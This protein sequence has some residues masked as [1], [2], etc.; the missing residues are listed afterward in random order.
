[1]VMFMVPFF[2]SFS[3][4][5]FNPKIEILRRRFDAFPEFRMR[6]IKVL[7]FNSDTS[8][9]INC[10]CAYKAT[11]PEIAA[12]FHEL[13]AKSIENGFFLPFP[14]ILSLGIVGA[15]PTSLPDGTFY[16]T[17]VNILRD[18]GIDVPDPL[19]VLVDPPP[20]QESAENLKI[21]SKREFQDNGVQDGPAVK[22][23]KMTTT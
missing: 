22:K 20:R 16:G 5:D 8:I 7:S 17:P 9:I 3:P 14:F 15:L 2:L 23:A 1:M 11:Y 6:F 21:G 10:K 19:P 18:N 4:P 12:I 13:K